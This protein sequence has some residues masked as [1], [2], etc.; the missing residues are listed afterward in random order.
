MTSHIRHHL[1]APSDQSYKERRAWHQE[2]FKTKPS[3]LHLV[4]MRTR[5]L[6]TADVILSQ[7]VS[8][9]VCVWALI[10][11]VWRWFF[12]ICSLK[13]LF[14]K[15]LCWGHWF[16]RQKPA[17]YFLSR[18]D[19]SVTHTFKDHQW[20]RKTSVVVEGW[21]KEIGLNPGVPHTQKTHLFDPHVFK[22]Y[23]FSFVRQWPR[24]TELLSVVLLSQC[25]SL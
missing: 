5:H 20:G 7:C 19:A 9:H 4:M 10:T 16:G 2:D 21:K 18:R 12:F 22:F 15:Q 8:Q 1:N 6:D 24:V 23:T 3:A 14:H 25:I 11:C 13:R 17:F